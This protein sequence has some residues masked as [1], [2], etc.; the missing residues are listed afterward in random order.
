MK[1]LGTE[2]TKPEGTFR[3]DWE[4]VSV[5]CGTSCYSSGAK[6]KPHFPLN[7]DLDLDKL[8]PTVHWS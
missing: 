2:E 1:L 6:Q 3:S 8:E 5:K 4:V 7:S